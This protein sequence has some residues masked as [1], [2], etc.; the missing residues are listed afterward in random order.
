MKNNTL[1]INTH[2]NSHPIEWTV[3][4]SGCHECTSHCRDRFGYPKVRYKGKIR[5][6]SRVVYS[7]FFLGGELVDSKLQVR[8]KCDNPKC[9]N[10]EHLELGTHLDNVQDM[11]KR[12]RKNPVKGS[13]SWNAKLTN[14]DVIQIRASN[15]SCIELSLKYPVCKNHIRAI[16]SGTSWRHLL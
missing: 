3:T 12:G 7:L 9:I 4:S 11:I 8:H 2:L 16:K 6:M 10:P 5:V 14:E 15:L 1:I 13:N